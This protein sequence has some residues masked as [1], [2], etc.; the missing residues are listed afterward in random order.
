MLDAPPTTY[1]TV[2]LDVVWGIQKRHGGSLGL[3]YTFKGPSLACVS[4]DESVLTERKQVAFSCYSY[5]LEVRDL[6]GRIGAILTEVE[7][8]LELGSIAGIDRRLFVRD[9]E[10]PVRIG[11]RG[12][13]GRTRT[14]EQTVMSEPRRLHGKRPIYQK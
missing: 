11:L 12:G 3:H 8:Q 9:R 10:S 1:M 14:S 4:H 13:S 6:I 7:D 2:N 5:F